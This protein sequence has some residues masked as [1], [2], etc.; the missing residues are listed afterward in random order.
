MA[1]SSRTLQL[2]VAEFALPVPRLGSI[3]LYSGYGAL[4]N[5][6]SEIHM[7]IQAER[8][9]ENSYYNA[10][11]W[12]SHTFA[13]GKYRIIVGG[14]MDGFLPGSP[15]LVEEIKTAYQPEALLDALNRNPAHPYRLQLQT[16]AYLHFLQT[17]TLPQTRLHIVSA[18]DRTSKD[19]REEFD[20]KSFEAWIDRR[21]TELINEDETFEKLKK[22]RKASAAAF[23]FPFQH[24]RPGQPELVRTIEENLSKGGLILAQAPTGLGKTAAV[25]FPVLREAMTRGQKAIYVTAKNSQHSVAE[26]AARRLQAT[27]AKVKSL[28]LHAK[29]KMCLKE[30]VLCNP[31]YCEYAKDYYTKVSEKKLADKL[32]KKKNLNQKTF[33]KF[34]RE[35]EVCPFELQMEV[36]SK[37]DLAICDYNY[38]FSP[39]NITGKLTYNGHGKNTPP[40]LIVDEAHNLPPRA[41]EYF[42]GRLS[43]NALDLEVQRATHLT[44]DLR[45]ALEGLAIAA[46]LRIRSSAAPGTE[47]R[48]GK[49]EIDERDFIELFQ[50]SQELQNNYIHS[51]VELQRNDPVLAVCHAISEFAQSLLNKSEE[52]FCTYTPEGPS[53]KITCCDASLWLR[54]CY[55]NFSNVVA[56]SATIK[57]F[58]YYTKILGMDG[59][60]L[61][62]AEFESPFPKS[63]RKLLIIPQVS[64]RLKDR[65]GNYK[66]IQSA[67]ERIVGLRKGNY[68]VF[69]PSFDFL[70][71]VAEGLNLPDF[72]ILKQSR[73]MRRDQVEYYLEKLRSQDKPTLIMAVQ[74]G[75]FAEG[76]DYPG[77]MLIGAII[78]GPALPTFDFERELLRE[79]YE[80]KYGNGFDYAYTYPAMAKVIQSAGRVIR[81]SEDR[82]LIV[83]MDRRFLHENYLRT[84]PADWLPEDPAALVSNKI[85]SDIEGF[86]NSHDEA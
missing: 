3:E 68:F 70:Y 11:R 13:R 31:E 38:V 73:E 85:L 22:R 40:N 14:R 8:L 51:G 64:T 83:L 32:V 74:G 25:T 45:D 75:V 56:F 15:P 81:S 48:A 71:K 82:G 52:F 18:R 6:G 58:D 50:R 21:L 80:G 57:P 7:E 9:K 72:D 66:K 54:E 55:A 86:W 29:G 39:R 35:H 36:V 34:G 26:D 41:N 19:L 49:V 20:L 28:T 37:A 1:G 69:F 2:G 62:T 65:A 44:P 33:L 12:I 46:R 23:T 59:P 76:V 53:L 78:V 60:D 42:S 67:I 43:A 16:Y 61:K 24:P 79:Y 17:G 5:V 10:E 84:M 30:E 4:P 63:H 27:G 47:N 77:Q